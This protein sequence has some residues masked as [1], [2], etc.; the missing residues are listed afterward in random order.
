M[1]KYEH[2]ITRRVEFSE[3]DMAGIVHFS[4]FFRY[5]ESAEH[6][7][8]RAV[9]LSV[10]T[11]V[12]GVHFGWPRVRA[13]CDYTSP[14]RFEDLVEVRV[15]VR[16]V[17]NK[18]LLLDFFF[19]KV[20]DGGRTPVARGALTTVCTQRNADGGMSAVAIPPQITEQLVSAPREA[21]EPS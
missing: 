2:T 3:T 10:A 21:L 19:T 11:N 7:L 17:R 18:A 16:E 1:S 14:L 6:D 15:V 9:G 5:M 20:S 13:E 12:D 8:F 4:Q